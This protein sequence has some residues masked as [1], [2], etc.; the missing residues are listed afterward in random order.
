VG[1]SPYDLEQA[2]RKALAPTTTGAG[3]LAARPPDAT[4]PT[5]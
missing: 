4:G 1:F 5:P 3:M 2:V